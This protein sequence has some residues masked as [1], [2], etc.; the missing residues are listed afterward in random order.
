M[1]PTW[2]K[3]FAYQVF[4]F[5][6]SVA[7]VIFVTDYA[8]TKTYEER[9]LNFVKGFSITAHSGCM[10]TE[11]N[12]LASLEAAVN[13][14]AQSVEFDVRMRSD[15]VLVMSHDI[16]NESK[17]VPVAK[18]LDYLADKNIEINFDVKESSCLKEL[19]AL[20]GEYGIIER[21]VITGIEV[22]DIKNVKLY[23]SDVEYYLNYSPGRLKIFASDYR[24]RL[25]SLLENTGAAG[26]NCNYKYASETLS[27][28]LHEN[29]Y[30][31]SVWTVDKER[32]MKR[33]LVLKPDNI[34]T[35]NVDVLKNVISEWDK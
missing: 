34:T 2:A 18:A 27:K 7:L 24:E 15:G 16:V 3:H 31:L 32:A 28:C 9:A 23:C 10:G 30:K 1:T 35:R 21:C 5:L 13:S 33:V 19:R 12:S 14:G 6:L 25:I 11:E 4:S 22:S 17:S 20:I 8:I 26:I 29:G